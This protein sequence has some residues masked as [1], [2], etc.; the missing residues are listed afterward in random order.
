MVIVKKTEEYLLLL[1]EMESILS[2]SAQYSTFVQHDKLRAGALRSIV[3]YR[4]MSKLRYNRVPMIDLNKGAKSHIA[5]KM[6]KD[7]SFVS[8]VDQKTKQRE[9][10]KSNMQLCG[11]EGLSQLLVIEFIIFNAFLINISLLLLMCHAT[12]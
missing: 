8:S 2:I 5:P 7:A 6:N 11:N 12:N 4:L 10:L 9:T 3:K 1:V